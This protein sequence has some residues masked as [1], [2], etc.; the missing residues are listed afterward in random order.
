MTNLLEP[1]TA[2]QQ[3]LIALIAETYHTH[4]GQAPVWEYIEL[5][6]DRLQLDAQATL[7]VLKAVQTMRNS[8][9]QHSGT[10]HRGVAAVK[11]LGLGYPIADAATAWRIIQRQVIPIIDGA[12]R[13]DSS[14]TEYLMP[15]SQV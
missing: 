13:G 1:L 12:T 11:S 6:F 5:E 15:S 7:Q 9:W 2:D 10:E 3:Q 14:G 4:N 8:L